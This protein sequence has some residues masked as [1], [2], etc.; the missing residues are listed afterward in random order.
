M[1]QSKFSSANFIFYGLP[2]KNPHKGLKMTKMWILLSQFCA[3]FGRFI[4][5][6]KYE[7][8]ENMKKYNFSS[9]IFLFYD[10]PLKMA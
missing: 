5:F 6:F 2:L 4:V 9:A 10:Q 1:K 7:K 3:F 8:Y